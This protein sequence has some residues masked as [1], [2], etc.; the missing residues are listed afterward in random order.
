M[1]ERE[2]EREKVSQEGIE[3]NYQEPEK[4]KKLNL[5]DENYQKKDEI[6]EG[7]LVKGVK[8]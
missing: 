1:R 5:K 8:D 7:K 2:R 4:E 3:N 6:K